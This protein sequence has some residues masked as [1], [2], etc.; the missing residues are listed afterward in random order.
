MRTEYDFSKSKKNPYLKKLKKQI[1]IRLDINT[2]E[3]FK[4]LS[5]DTGI[6]YQNLIN[7]YLAD[8]VTKKRKPKLV[9]QENK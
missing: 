2:I 4:E 5:A 8:C 1:S 7:T 6:P 9:W 3:Y